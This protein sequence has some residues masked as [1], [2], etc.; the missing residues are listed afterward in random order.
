MPRAIENRGH[1]R[2]EENCVCATSLSRHF[3]FKG[4]IEAAPL[5][6]GFRNSPEIADSLIKQAEEK[7]V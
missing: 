2:R 1:D 4:P 6:I 3:R 7:T 5:A